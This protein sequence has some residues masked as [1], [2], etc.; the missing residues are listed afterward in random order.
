MLCVVH[1]LVKL[2]IYIHTPWRRR[3]CSTSSRAAAHTHHPTSTQ[4]DG[5]IFT[6]THKETQIKRQG[7]EVR[8]SGQAGKGGHIEELPSMSCHR[9]LVYAHDLAR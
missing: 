8:H 2:S 3:R 9:C 7:R 1:V 4:T 5:S 6:T